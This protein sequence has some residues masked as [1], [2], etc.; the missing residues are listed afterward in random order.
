MHFNPTISNTSTIWVAI[1]IFISLKRKLKKKIPVS[2]KLDHKDFIESLF[3]FF[4]LRLVLSVKLKVIISDY[5]R[6]GQK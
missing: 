6:L 4:L 3:N 1:G 5:V 2:Q